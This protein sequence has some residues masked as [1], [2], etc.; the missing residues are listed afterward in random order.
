MWGFCQYLN[1]F[2]ELKTSAIQSI[3]QYTTFVESNVSDSMLFYTDTPYTDELSGITI[4]KGFYPAD[5]STPAGDFFTPGSSLYITFNTP[6]IFIDTEAFG[7]PLDAVGYADN[8]PFLQMIN[9][10]I[11]DGIEGTT[12]DIFPESTNGN[13]SYQIAD[14]R[15]YLQRGLAQ[16]NPDYRPLQLI[17]YAEQ[18]NLTPGTWINLT[19]G[20]DVPTI[21]VGQIRNLENDMISSVISAGWTQ[22]GIVIKPASVIVNKKK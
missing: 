9:E 21:I 16:G 22:R 2:P 3:S 6:D 8:T 15:L 20:G 13:G 19:L 10:L 11:T 17:M 7:P 12:I 4:E 18:N 5:S 1:G 14:G